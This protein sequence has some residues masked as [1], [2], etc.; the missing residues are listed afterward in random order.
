M[1]RERLAAL[2]LAAAVV[3][4]V[5]FVSKEPTGMAQRQGD[6]G[7]IDL[8]K[9]WIE[10]ILPALEEP[11][12]QETARLQAELDR[13]VVGRPEAEKQQLFDSYQSQLYAFQQRLVDELL[14]EVRRAIA[15]V[16]EE[17]GLSVVLDSNSVMYGGIDITEPV[18]Q[19]L[20][21]Q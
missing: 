19:R 9:I 11:L 20:Q 12:R 1:K 16:A 15:I 7:V 21:D 14:Q 4:I 13:A 2:L 3:G 10:S 5:L 6:I 8:E 18:L 17:L